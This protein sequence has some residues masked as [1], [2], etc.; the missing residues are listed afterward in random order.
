MIGVDGLRLLQEGRSAREALDIVVAAD[1]GAALRQA[2][3]LD[4]DGGIA[5]FTV[6]PVCRGAAPYPAAMSQLPATCSPMNGSS[7]IRSQLSGQCCLDF[8]DR[9]LAALEAG[10]QAGGDKR[11]RQSAAIRIWDKD[12]FPV[13]DIRVDDHAVPLHEMRRLWRKAHQRYVPF[14]ACGPTR[15]NPGA[16]PIAPHSTRR[17]TLTLLPGMRPTPSNKKRRLMAG[18]FDFE[19]R[20]TARLEE[21]LDLTL[22]IQPDHVSRGHL[23][24]ARHGH[25]IAGYDT[26]N[27]APAERR[28]SRTGTT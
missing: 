23:G 21:T 26:M 3:I 22:R 7:P 9:L 19:R 2:H 12:V 14:Q 11:G 20:G 25:D 4:R 27:S 13:I 10:E 8:D 28:N 24:Q 5:A 6:T 1:P 16:S 17:A 18:A 15:A